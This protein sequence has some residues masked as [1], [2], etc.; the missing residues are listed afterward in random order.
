[1]ALSEAVM[2]WN[3]LTGKQAHL[4]EHVVAI[5]VF[6]GMHIGHRALFAMA[7]QYARELDA[8]LIAISF[9]QDPDEVFHAEDANFGKLLSN[10]RRL[11]M[12]AEQTDDG[13]LSLPA[14]PEVFCIEAM[15]FLDYLGSTLTP[16]AF[17]VGTDFHFGA[18]ARGSVTDI[19]AWCADHDCAC[20]P[21]ELIEEH[22]LP[23]T[24]TR[25]RRLLMAGEVAEARELLAGRPHSVIG[26]VVHGRGEGGD[27]GFATANLDLSPN[28]TMLVREGVYGAY[29]YVDERRYAAAVNVGVSKTF[30]DATA[31]VEAHL[32]DFEGDLYGKELKIEFMN[33]L[34][35][36]RVFKTTDELVTTVMDNINW[37]REHLGG[38]SNGAHI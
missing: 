38:E 8:P 30:S 6:D 1:M 23:I 16:R 17:F 24:A 28:E 27:L 37:V 32:I 12:I 2:H 14:T 26:R 25:I 22:G 35:E 21:C 4:G 3:P 29:V 13:V 11:Q 33:W 10:S 34:R 15:S 7:R 9:D 31:A 5:G 20:V 18:Q 19:E 36:P